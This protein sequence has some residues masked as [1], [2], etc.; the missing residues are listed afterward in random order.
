[1]TMTL[2]AAPKAWI[3]ALLA[4][5]VMVMVTSHSSRVSVFYVNYYAHLL[6]VLCHGL[7]AA[8]TRFCCEGLHH[9]R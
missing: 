1:M 4:K 6:I 2:T 3:S 7:R 5:M 8:A 9:S